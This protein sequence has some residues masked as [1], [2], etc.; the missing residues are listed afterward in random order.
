MDPMIDIG[1]AAI[2]R[3]ES[4]RAQRTGNFIIPCSILPAAFAPLSERPL[5]E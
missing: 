1:S 3:G 2:G 4:R 5:S